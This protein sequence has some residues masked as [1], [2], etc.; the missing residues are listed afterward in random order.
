[1]RITT[2]ARILTGGLALLLTTT[3]CSSVAENISERAAEE[4]LE[5]AAGGEVDIDLD[6]DGGTVSVNTD[7]GSFSIG[8]DE[9]P[10]AFPASAP[11]PADYTVLSS[12]SGDS[13][14]DGQTVVV[15]VS[16]GDAS[17]EDLVARLDAE[18]AANGWDVTER[19][20]LR[21]NGFEQIVWMVTS[22][23]WSGQITVGPGGNGETFNVSYIFDTSSA[24]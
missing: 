20:D 24:E 7:D 22:A 3:A 9:L 10:D 4:I 8:T 18:L 23:S 6:E 21:A 12:M 2:H 19:S 1:M 13:S 17:F 16:A 15:T 11:L 14:D 5:Q